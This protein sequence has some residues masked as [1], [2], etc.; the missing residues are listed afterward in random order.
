MP[1]QPQNIPAND[2]IE[3]GSREFWQQL[4]DSPEALAAE[5]CSIDTSD[6]EQT[7]KH[8][9]A[10]VAWVVAA[11]EAARI[12]EE[13][14]KW[15]LTRTKATALLDAK[16]DKD[17]QSGKSK[18]VAVLESEVEDDDRVQKAQMD[19]LDAQQIRG[20]LKAMAD[21]MRDRRDMLVQI[22]AKQ[23]DEQREY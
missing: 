15:I 6:L 18:T 12:G 7:M 10:L 14:A 2:P 9:P 11:Y 1:I 13:K 4:K 3:L 21:T 23:R 20:S 22:S 19:L 17:P 8:H 16:K 5:V